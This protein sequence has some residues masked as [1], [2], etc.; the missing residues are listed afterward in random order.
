MLENI[1]QEINKGPWKETATDA[2]GAITGE[3]HDTSVQQTSLEKSRAS[4]IASTEASTWYEAYLK[5]RTALNDID[6]KDELIILFEAIFKRLA[7]KIK[8]LEG[9]STIL[10]LKIIELEAAAKKDTEKLKGLSEQILNSEN[11][12]DEVFDEAFDK[13]FEV[14]YGK[15]FDKVSARKL[16]S[17]IGLKALQLISAHNGEG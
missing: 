9:E 17:D 2:S 10:L 13:A 1:H 11:T 3:S 6:K 8:E 4:L 15:A 12:F 14:V 7:D 16:D 5:L